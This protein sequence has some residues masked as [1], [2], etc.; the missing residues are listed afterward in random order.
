MKKQILILMLLVFVVSVFGITIINFNDNNIM[1]FTSVRNHTK[2]ITI[3]KDAIINSAYM[4]ITGSFSES[5]FPYNFSG[6]GVACLNFT[7]N[8]FESVSGYP[9]CDLRFD[10]CVFG[11]NYL[12][13]STSNGA[14]FSTANSEP[15]NCNDNTI[16]TGTSTWSVDDYICINDSKGDIRI[17]KFGTQSAG[18]NSG[19]ILY[20][21]YTNYTDYSKNYTYNPFITIDNDNTFSGECYQ[22]SPIT[23]NQT[24][25]DSCNLFYTG[26][27]SIDNC[28]SGIFDCSTYY[29][30]DWNTGNISGNYYINYIKPNGAS[31]VK[32][33]IKDF[34]NITNITIPGVCYNT[35]DDYIS[36][37]VSSDTDFLKTTFY[38]REGAAWRELILNNGND[39]FYEEAVIWTINLTNENIFSYTGIYNITNQ[40]NDFSEQ[41]GRALESGSCTCSGCSLNG[42]NCTVDFIFHS[43][44]I[45]KITLNELNINWTELVK[46]NITIYE[47][48]SNITYSNPAI[49]L[50]ISVS[51][52]WIVD[53]CVYWVPGVVSNTTYDCSYRTFSATSS[54]VFS[55][56]VCVY[57]ISG[58]INCTSKSFTTS[59]S[60]GGGG[61]GST[62]TGN[63]N[64]IIPNAGNWTMSTVG[65]T[66]NYQLKM[67]KSSTRD[68]FILFENLGTNNR[69]IS[70]SCINL[71][72]TL[73][74]YVTFDSS[75][76]LPAL[77]DIKTSKEVNIV[78]PSN[79]ENGE[80][81]F[82]I[83]ARDEL[84]NEAIITYFID[85]GN[86][87]LLTNALIKAGSSVNIFG[88]NIPV[89]I[90]ALFIGII[91]WA[92]VYFALIKTSFGTSVSFIAGLLSMVVTI[93]LI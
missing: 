42:N 11:C 56:N 69:Q 63:S 66:D 35:Y 52:N 33:Q 64:P 79:T 88:L 57:D 83:K 36:L 9:P 14:N 86:F 31:S 49:P 22:E 37:F 58:N 41:L 54:G 93:L 15:E 44:D 7:D 78:L 92:V 24:G 46:P 25:I 82:N 85:V 45:G 60:L 26:S 12:T 50:N 28:I 18:A 43:D 38:C 71:N 20:I 21:N 16:Y 30:G 67:T 81:S 74:N 3:S 40:T 76:E 34:N 10:W 59:I 80:Y 47:P 48:D 1:D 62:Q 29:D 84:G 53:Y 17:L 90:V 89:L 32:W 51:D 5:T 73:C 4:N 77:S 65:I 27:L 2:N 61:S 72:G 6:N 68:T 91:I 70:L 75:F 8:T 39:E 19:T 13:I 23:N 55:L 87:G